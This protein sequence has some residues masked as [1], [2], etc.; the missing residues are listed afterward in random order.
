MELDQKSEVHG[1]QISSIVKTLLH[2]TEFW[3]VC[4][5][6]LNGVNSTSGSAE[7]LMWPEP[8]LILA[9]LQHS[10]AAKDLYWYK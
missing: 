6:D 3:W 1:F 10:A 7:T 9:F 8:F 4:N 5:S 2:V